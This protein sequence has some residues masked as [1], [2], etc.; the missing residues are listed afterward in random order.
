[1]FEKGKFSFLASPERSKDRVKKE[2]V[3]EDG[4]SNITMKKEKTFLGEMWIIGI[5]KFKRDKTK[6]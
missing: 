2:I 6:N 1:M 4:P 5:F 3:K